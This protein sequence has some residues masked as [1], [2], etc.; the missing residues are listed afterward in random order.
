MIFDAVLDSLLDCLYFLELADDDVV[1][2]DDA[3]KVLESVAARLGDL[4]DAE[5]HDLTARILA[6]AA[7]EP[8]PATRD[9]LE[10]VPE[11]YGLIELD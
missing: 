9:F 2:P 5:R 6:R 3:L 11:S 7:A 4:P 1:D 8:D 10:G